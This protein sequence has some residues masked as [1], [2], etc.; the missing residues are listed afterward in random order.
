MSAYIGPMPNLTI[1]VPKELFE[2]MRRHR[3]VKWSEVLRRAIAE[4]LRSLEGAEV[5]DVSE[6]RKV[7][8]DTGISLDE[9]SLERAIEHYRKMG[10]LEWKRASTIRA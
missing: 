3:E 5:V 6:L 8:S 1:A 4:Y 2:R 7:V 10:E 9:I